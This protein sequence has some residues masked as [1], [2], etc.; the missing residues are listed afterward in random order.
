MPFE[1]IYS[2]IQTYEHIKMQESVDENN[3]DDTYLAHTRDF[4]LN[5]VEADIVYLQNKIIGKN[6]VQEDPNYRYKA[7]YKAKDKVVFSID[8]TPKTDSGSFIIEET[9]EVIAYACNGVGMYDGF[10]AQHEGEYHAYVV[11]C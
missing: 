6:H 9:G 5:E 11:Q 4:I 1:A 3:L 8:Q 10:H 7:W 2:D